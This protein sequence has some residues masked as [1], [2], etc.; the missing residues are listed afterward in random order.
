MSRES[1]LPKDADGPL[2]TTDAGLSGTAGMYGCVVC[3]AAFA[4]PRDL[5]AHINVEHGRGQLEM[6]RE[7]DKAIAAAEEEGDYDRP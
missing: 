7:R 4:T 2:D 1:G 3:G 6:D 5:E